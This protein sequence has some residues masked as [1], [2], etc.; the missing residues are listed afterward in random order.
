MFVIVT[1]FFFS[2]AIITLNLKISVFLICFGFNST[3]KKTK[4]N[5]ANPKVSKLYQEKPKLREKK[6]NTY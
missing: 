2:H 6:K 1:Q 4:L 5:R 3:P